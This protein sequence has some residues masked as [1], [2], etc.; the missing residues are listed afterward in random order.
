MSWWPLTNR[1][2][3]CVFVF[4][5][6]RSY[7]RYLIYIKLFKYLMKLPTKWIKISI[8][9]MIIIVRWSL[10][11]Q[12]LYIE[13]TTTRVSHPPVIMPGH[14]Q[15]A[16]CCSDVTC[17]H[18]YTAPACRQQYSSAGPGWDCRLRSFLIHTFLVLLLSWLSV[19]SCSGAVSMVL[20]TI[21]LP[22]T[23]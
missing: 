7:L 11:Y 13:T 8:K 18:C 9:Y 22:C 21:T 2:H 14:Q 1:T 4:I 5:F 15:K 3:N 17:Y 16:V 10:Y 23:A 12:Y 19:Q 20:V 6:V